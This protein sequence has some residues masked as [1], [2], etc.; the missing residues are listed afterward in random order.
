M[1]YFRPVS[2]LA[3]AATS[4][5]A[6]TFSASAVTI[7][8]STH[9]SLVTHEFSDDVAFAPYKREGGV[10]SG[11]RFE[12]DKGALKITNAYAG[13]FGI[14]TKVPAFNAEDYGHLF[15]D[16]LIPPTKDRNKVV[17][18]NIF[19]RLKGVYHGVNFTGPSEVRPG[20]VFLGTIAKVEADGKWHRAH[21]PIRDWLRQIYPREG[22][23]QVEEVVIGNWNSS[24]YLM[25]GIGGN[26]AGANWQMDNFSIT[27]VGPEEAKFSVLD[28]P[29]KPLAKPTEYSYALDGAA[30]TALKNSDI[31][32]SAS[33]G[34]HVLQI[35]DKTKKV[36][37]DYGFFVAKD[38]PLAGK[39]QLV[40]NTL[41]IPIATSAGLNFKTVKLVVGDRTFESDSPYLTWNGA[42]G[43]L[44]LDAGNA[45]LTWKD[46]QQIPVAI[47]G[48]TDALG[49][50]LPAFKST[51]AVDY[52]NL[53]T[54]PS[55]PQL[56]ELKGVGTGTFE[57]SLDDWSPRTDVEGAAI[58][59]RDNT[60]RAGGRYS[61]RLTSPINSAAMGAW[62]RTVKSPFE[63]TKCP[64]IEFDYR[65]S[66]DVRVDFLLGLGGQTYSIG[67]TDR[68][69]QY[70]RL[71]QIPDIKADDQW[72]HASINLLEMIQKAVPPIT[73]QQVDWLALGDSGYIGNARG[74][75]FWIDN[76]QLVAVAKG[77]PF[78][79]QVTLADVTG[80]KA[81]SW[82]LDDNATTIPPATAKTTGDVLK[83]DGAGRQWLHVR[84][85]NGAGH[86]SETS[87]RP[88]VLSPA[89]P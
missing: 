83:A 89:T 3:L 23:L 53:K 71:G 8:S 39:I 87:H 10:A 5:C 66:P 48:T 76:F 68:T 44:S 29:G 77:A 22:Q 7:T 51:L 74:D 70:T 56:A 43:V 25:A 80:V 36:V 60:T 50:A 65:I 28:E 52:S 15:F 54:D 27:G 18:V 20:S 49:R 81:L 33:N 17:R 13:S 45:G 14:D 30:A 26:G 24:N 86:W 84:A 85:Q 72:H 6:L 21:V 59:E 78:I 34:F 69:P 40:H 41:E 67:F 32:V 9:P 63:V 82:I 42:T 38:A 55:L 31:A 75:Q 2:S 88:L 58:V 79:S 16:Y 73:A 37:A 1:K 64:H 11:A 12:I 47:E 61:V 4:F 57:D 35:L 46:G 62:I 19:L